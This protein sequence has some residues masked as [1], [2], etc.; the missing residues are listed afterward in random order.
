MKDT[1]ARCLFAGFDA[2]DLAL[3]DETF[4]SDYARHAGSGA[5]SVGSL[6][7]HKADVALMWDAIEGATYEINELVAEGDTV[8]T[9]FTIAGRHV[10]EYHGRAAT[11]ERVRLRFVAFF[12]FR[13]D[14]IASSHVMGDWQVDAGQ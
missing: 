14:K 4:H 2:H 9:R 7:A 1:V 10:G 8:A 3:M 6:E 11:N 13:G 12:H 5:A